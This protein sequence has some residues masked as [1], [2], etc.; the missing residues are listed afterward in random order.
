MGG[1]GSA[2]GPLTPYILDG[3]RGRGQRYIRK[4]G[5]AGGGDDRGHSW[6]DTVCCLGSIVSQRVCVPAFVSARGG[7]ERVLARVRS[8]DLT[9]LFFFLP[10]PPFAAIRVFKNFSTCGNLQKKTGSFFFL[11][12]HHFILRCVVSKLLFWEYTGKGL[13]LFSSCIRPLYVALLYCALY[14]VFGNCIFPSSSLQLPV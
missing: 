4:R 10:P 1:S 5:C 7:G 13:P 9:R 14:I 2:P 11:H 8:E 12:I 6:L 3:G